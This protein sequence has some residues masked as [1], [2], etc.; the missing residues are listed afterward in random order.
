VAQLVEWLPS[1][2]K[3]CIS[4]PAP[5]KTD[6]VHICNPNICRSRRIRSYIVRT[7]L[8]HIRLSEG[9]VLEQRRVSLLLPVP[10]TATAHEVPASSLRHDGEDQ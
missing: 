10:E 9:N 2:Q 5:H 8:R 4:F 1:M 7:D 3:S 6:V